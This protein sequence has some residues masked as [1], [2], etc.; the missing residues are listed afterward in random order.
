MYKGTHSTHMLPAVV[1]ILPYFFSA[2]VKCVSIKN[3]FFSLA[4]LGLSFILLCFL[5][6]MHGWF[7]STLCLWDTSIRMGVM[8]LLIDVDNVMHVYI[9]IISIHCWYTIRLFHVL[10]FLFVFLSSIT[11]NAA[12]DIFS[13]V[14]WFAEARALFC[15]SPNLKVLHSKV[16]EVSTVV[17]QAPTSWNRLY[18]N[19]QML[20]SLSTQA[21]SWFCQ[22]FHILQ[23]D[24]MSCTSWCF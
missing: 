12:R 22:V 14:K 19:T 4:H 9:V 17:S 10:E 6:S 1:N 18:H 20:S 13:V 2:F 11:D 8:W 15:V 24:D 23:L 16:C 21:H 7:C 5:G 3:T